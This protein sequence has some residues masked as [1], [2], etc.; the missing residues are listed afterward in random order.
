MFSLKKFKTSA[1]VILA[2]AFCVAQTANEYESP[3][4]IDIAGKLNCN[5][6]C[7]LTMKCVMPPSG[8]CPTCRTQKI[9]IASMLKSGMTEQQVLDEYVKE[10][11]QEVLVVSPGTLGYTGPYIALGLGLVGVLFT[12]RYLQKKKAAPVVAPANDAQLARYHDQI[13][14]DLEKF[15]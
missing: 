2:A 10:R 13:E 5:C 8:V 3:Q 6:G 4:V 7:H 11:G 9:R 12:L 1:L 15:D 14:K